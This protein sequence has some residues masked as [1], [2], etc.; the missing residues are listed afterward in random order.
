M[1]QNLWKFSK[2]EENKED[3]EDED[4]KREDQN[5]QNSKSTNQVRQ[6]GNSINDG[7]SR[8]SKDIT[9]YLPELQTSSWAYLE[10]EM[11]LEIVF[12]FWKFKALEDKPILEDFFGENLHFKPASMNILIRLLVAY[13]KHVLVLQILITL[14]KSNFHNK[15][16][17]DSNT[18]KSFIEQLIL[19]LVEDGQMFLF[20]MVV[21]D[22]KECIRNLVAPIVLLIDNF[23]F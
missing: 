21:E 16:D 2:E 10:I 11:V 4:E 6:E 20:D 23:D 7:P 9:K 8:P 1:S 15:Q 22:F 12:R 18:V 13:E 19:S 5:E 14:E 17:S 3:K